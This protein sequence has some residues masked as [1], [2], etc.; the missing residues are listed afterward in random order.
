MTTIGFIG[1]GNI[2][3]S[4]ARAAIARGDE[5]A[6]EGARHG[7]RAALDVVEDAV[8]LRGVVVGVHHD[9]AG[10]R[11]DGKVVHGA[12]RDRHH[13]QIAGRRRLG[14]RRGARV[15][16]EFGDQGVEGLDRKSVV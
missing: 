2:G 10:E 9:L 12:E 8:A 3:S 1:S 6:L 16:A 14:H 7:D 13:H 15:R 5:V 4:I 11:L